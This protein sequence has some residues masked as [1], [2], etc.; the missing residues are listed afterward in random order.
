MPLPSGPSAVTRTATFAPARRGGEPDRDVVVLAPEHD[1]VRGRRLEDGRPRRGPTRPPAAAAEGRS[2]PRPRPTRPPS[3]ASSAPR[4]TR[5]MRC[6]FSQA[7]ASTATSTPVLTSSACPYEVWTT[8][9]SDGNAAIARGIE[10]APSTATAPSAIG[11]KRRRARALPLRDEQDEPADPD[12]GRGDVDEVGERDQRAVVPGVERVPGQRR[13]G[14]LEHRR[15]GGDESRRRN[16]ERDERRRDADQSDD[17]GRLGHAAEAG[18]VGRRL[19][20]QQAEAAAR[21]QR[22]ARRRRPRS[23]AGAGRARA[24]PAR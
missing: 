14:E 1:R 13:R 5:A 19:D 15:R 3:S 17:R 22:P 6:R 16:R 12:R 2:A 24:G 7:T 20:R 9:A 23:R 10:A 18:R 21:D 8:E 4:P 11:G